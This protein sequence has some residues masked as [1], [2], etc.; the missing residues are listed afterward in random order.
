MYIADANISG[1]KIA[2]NA[3]TYVCYC[4][5]VGGVTNGYVAFSSAGYISNIGWC[6]MLPAIGS[7]V[8]TT[9]AAITSTLSSIPFDDNGYVIVVVSDMDDLCV[10][11]KWSAKRRLILEQNMCP[12]TLMVN[13]VLIIPRLI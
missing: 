3:G 12:I 9:G 7:D 6:A 2:S 5:A 4:R 10:H 8:V 11:P 13:Y 1:G